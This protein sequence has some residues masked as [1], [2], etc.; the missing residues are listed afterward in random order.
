MLLSLIFAAGG[1]ARL[2]RWQQSL[3]VD[4]C[5]LLAS[6]HGVGGALLL[7][8]AIVGEYVGR[9]LEQVRGRPMYIVKASSDDAARRPPNEI[10][11]RLRQNNAA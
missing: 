11:D 6:I 3:G 4:S 7:S 2:L 1:V 10:A 8:L 9:I 5:V